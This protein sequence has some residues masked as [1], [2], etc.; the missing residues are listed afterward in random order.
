LETLNQYDIELYEWVK[1]RFTK[2]IEPLDPD[3]SREVCHFEAVIRNY[4]RL[5]RVFGEP[6]RRATGYA[7]SFAKLSVGRILLRR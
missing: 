6:V 2:Q 4:H 3:F 1:A 7:K 5:D